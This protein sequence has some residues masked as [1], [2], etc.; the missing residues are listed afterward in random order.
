VTGRDSIT[1]KKSEP[2]VTVRGS[3]GDIV[4]FLY[5][6]SSVARV[7]FDGPSDAVERLKNTRFGI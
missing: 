2:T 3:V 6:R 4:L 7:E 1:A 5:G